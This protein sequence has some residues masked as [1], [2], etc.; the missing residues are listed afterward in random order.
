MLKYVILCKNIKI[1][2]LEINDNGQHKYTPDTSGI[3]AIKNEVPLLNDLLHETDWRSPIPFFENRIEDAKRFSKE[4]DIQ[5]HT[6]PFRMIL[7]DAS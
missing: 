1:G 3:D 4:K 5:N 2:I 7:I 6:D